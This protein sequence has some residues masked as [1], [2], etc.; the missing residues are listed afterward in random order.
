MN[1]PNTQAVQIFMT[2]VDDIVNI[3]C[4]EEFNRQRAGYDPYEEAHSESAL[5]MEEDY[6]ESDVRWGTM[7]TRMRLESKTQVDN[8]GLEFKID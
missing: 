4:Y 8:I 5:L 7:E 3:T 1:V 6:S 2:L